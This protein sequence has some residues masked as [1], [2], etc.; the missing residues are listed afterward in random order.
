[1]SNPVLLL[2]ASSLWIGMRNRQEDPILAFCKSNKSGK[3]MDA[4]KLKWRTLCVCNHQIRTQMQPTPSFKFPQSRSRS[5][6]PISRNRHTNTKQHGHWHGCLHGHC[7]TVTSRSNDVLPSPAERSS[8]DEASRNP[9]RQ[10]IRLDTIYRGPSEIQ[11]RTFYHSEVAEQG[12]WNR[13]SFK[14]KAR[15]AQGFSF[16]THNKVSIFQ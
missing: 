15:Q 4:R 11:G 13:S 5:P 9:S 7:D 3:L 8:T 1:M 2:L 12:C 10:A 16:C 14:G 6:Y